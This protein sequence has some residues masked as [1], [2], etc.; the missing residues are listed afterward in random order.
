MGF[1]F[2]RPRPRFASFSARR[3]ISRSSITASLKKDT[4]NKSF[5]ASWYSGQTRMYKLKALE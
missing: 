3:M 5:K 4:L 2:V 1:G